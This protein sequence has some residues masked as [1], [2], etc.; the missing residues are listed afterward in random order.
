[1]DTLQTGT[2]VIDVVI[3]VTVIEWLAL[4]LLWRRRGRGVPPGVLS[5]MLLPGLALM[6]AVRGVMLGLP[7]YWLALLLSLSGLAHAVDMRSRWRY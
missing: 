7:W 3:A 1:M 2:H 4:L 6:L 5:W